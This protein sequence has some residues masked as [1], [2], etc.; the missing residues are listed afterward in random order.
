MNQ[1]KVV[2]IQMAD[3]DFPT[4]MQKNIL[5][6]YWITKIWLA[7]QLRGMDQKKPNRVNMLVDEIFQAPTALSILEYILVQLESLV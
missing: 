3:G 7:S 5:V 6:T 4:R 2:L 1:G